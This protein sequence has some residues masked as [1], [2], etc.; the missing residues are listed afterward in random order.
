MSTIELMR[1]IVRDHQA[2]EIDGMLVDATTANLCIKIH[3]ALSEINRAK[4]AAMPLARMVD[5]VWKLAG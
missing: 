5:V 2:E 3:D 4:F 1:A